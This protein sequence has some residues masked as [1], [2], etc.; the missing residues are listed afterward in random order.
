MFA[1]QNG[2]KTIISL[3]GFQAREVSR[4]RSGFTGKKIIKK[5]VYARNAAG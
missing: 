1:L 3:P 5:P 2:A 4:S